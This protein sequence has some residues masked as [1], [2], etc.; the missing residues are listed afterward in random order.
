[1]SAK[2][3]DRKRNWKREAGWYGMGP[4]S[5]SALHKN[6]SEVLAVTKGQD[7]PKDRD[8]DG[9]RKAGAVQKQVE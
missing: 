8:N 1:M 2:I 6:A 9:H 3:E 4:C 7:A 5:G